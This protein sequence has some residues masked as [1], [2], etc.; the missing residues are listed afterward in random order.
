MWEFDAFI[1]EGDE[2][3]ASYVERFEHYCKVAGVQDEELK[4]SAFISAIG[5]KAYKTLKDLLLPAKPEKKTFEDLVKVLSG[6]YEPSSQVI[7]E[8]FK[9]NRRYQGEGESVTAFAVTLK[10]MAAKCN[11]GTFLDDA[12]RDRFV[13]GLRN[14]TIQT[15]LLKRRE[16]TFESAS[17][18]A[19]SV[20]LAE[21]ESRGFRPTANTD[22]DIHALKKTG[23][24]LEFASKPKNSSMQSCYRCGQEHD[25][26]CCRYRKF[27]CHLCKRVGHLARMCRCKQ[28]APGAVHNVS[29]EASGST[30]LLLYGVYLVGMEQPYEVE[31]QIAGQLV[32]MQVDTGAAV[33]LVPECVYQQLK[34]P[35]QLE[36]CEMKLKTY[37]RATLQVKGQ[38][39]VLVD[40]KRQ[41]KVL[42]IIVVPGEKPALLGRDWIANLGMD[43]NSIHEVHAQPSV[44]SILSRYASVFSPGLGLIKCYQAKLVLKEG[45]MLVFCKA[46]SLP[47]AIREPVEHELGNLQ[48]E[49]VLV[50]VNRSDW[51]T[52]LVAVH[53]PDGTIRLCGDYKLTV[54]PCVKTDHYPLPAVEDLFTTLA[55]GKVF[56]VLD[57]S[58]AYQQ[59]EVHPDSQPL[60][61]INSHMG[62][63]QYV[64][65]PYG[66]S[67]AP[68]VFQAVINELL[69]GLPGVVCYLDDVLIT[70]ASHTECLT[71]VE[72]VLQAFRDHGVK[73]RKEKCKFFLNSVK[74]LGHIIDENGVHPCVE[75]VEA[76]R[77]APTPNNISELKA[78]LSMITF[79]SKFMLNMSSRLKPLYAL[80]QKNKKWV[81]SAKEE[82][83]FAEMQHTKTSPY[84]PASNG[85]AERLV[86]TVKRSFIKQL[87]DE[88]NAGV[89]Q[90]MQHRVDQFLFTYRNTLCSTT[91]KTP[92]ELFLSWR[93][94]TRLSIL[95]PELAKRAEANIVRR[96][97]QETH[98]SW[99]EFEVGDNVRVRGNRPS[100]PRWLKGT[101]VRRVSKGTYIVRIEDHER[102]LHA[103][104]IVPNTCLAPLPRSVWI[105]EQTR[106]AQPGST[107]SQ[108]DSD[109]ASP[110][111]GPAPEQRLPPP[112]RA[113]VTEL[114]SQQA[115]DAS[116][117]E[118]VAPPELRRSTRIRK[119]PEHFGYAAK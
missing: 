119:P 105:P 97:G 107:P 82:K 78:Y 45:S 94:R 49:G 29:D 28:P 113:S 93:P 64:R 114:P 14:S 56:T 43:L 116:S 41:R 86:Q 80:L 98:T 53:K 46:W 6:H 4:K 95:H 71:R 39:E 118:N 91:G 67:S 3:F 74:Y 36:K 22:A 44:D 96:Q 32:K 68:A 77:E 81:W 1:E 54:N 25:A 57:L 70:G 23:K 76:I 33:S 72:A 112:D 115:P 11:Y 51:A 21:R 66:V 63:F 30:E 24:E 100:D 84:H 58:T 110:P 55:G 117:Q 7:A 26:R 89:T 75:K 103:D 40:Y 52:P 38:A 87:R 12:L 48:K 99:R 102:F 69:K 37:G 101:V 106:M 50:P 85:T 61:T 42:P 83:A 15:G 35:P 62:L 8:R 111:D 47:C 79:Y 2:D 27:K 104:D 34:Q 19:K 16:L 90:T 13:A 92:A 31:V 18:F 5:K 17:V 65:M 20:E 59:I 10:H 73:V 60:L 9:F 108:S 109:T 88:Q